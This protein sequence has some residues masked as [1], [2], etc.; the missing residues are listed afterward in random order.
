MEENKEKD[1]KFGFTCPFCKWEGEDKPLTKE[2]TEIHI[3][4]KEEVKAQSTISE[5][6]IRSI[7]VETFKQHLPNSPNCFSQFLE[8]YFFMEGLIAKVLRKEEDK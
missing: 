7:F 4:S 5:N 8:K 1:L 3:V 6:Q 2:N